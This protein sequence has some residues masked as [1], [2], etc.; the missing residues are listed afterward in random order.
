MTLSFLSRIADRYQVGTVDVLAALVEVDGRLNLVG[1]VRP[2]S[3]VYLN[4][5]ARERLAA[6]SGVP[7]ERLRRA[8]PAWT[9]YE[10]RQP[11]GAGR[12]ECS[13]TEWRRSRPKVRRVLAAR[14]PGPAARL[15]PAGTWRP[16]SGSAHAT[17]SG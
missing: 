7:Q 6:L 3:E 15:P 10:P 11:Y 8:L 2:D 13:T 14:R 12:R 17:G 5:G 16:I 4:G 9:Q 1:G